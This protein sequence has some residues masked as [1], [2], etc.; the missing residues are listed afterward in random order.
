VTLLGYHRFGEHHF[1]SIFSDVPSPLGIGKLNDNY[2]THESFAALV[3]AIHENFHV[4][5]E[6]TQGFSLWNWYLDHDLAAHMAES[7]N[8]IPAGHLFKFPRMPREPSTPHSILI[9]RDDPADL[10]RQRHWERDIIRRHVASSDLAKEIIEVSTAGRG[11]QNVP[12]DALSLTTLDL[13][14]CHAAI[15][16]E[17]YIATL[18]FEQPENFSQKITDDLAGLFRVHRMAPEYNRALRIVLQL[19]QTSPGKFERGNPSPAYQHI[20]QP[21]AYEMTAFLL[22]YA[23]HTPPDPSVNVSNRPDLCAVEDMLPVVRFHKLLLAYWKQLFTVNNSGGRVALDLGRLYS[24]ES[25][26]LAQTINDANRSIRDEFG[27]VAI[28]VE[29]GTRADTFISLEGATHLWLDRLRK[30]PALRQHFPEL[31]HARMKSLELRLSDPNFW[32]SLQPVEFAVAVNVPFLFSK[33]RSGLQYFPLFVVPADVIGDEARDE[34]RQKCVQALRSASSNP[35]SAFVSKSELP[36]YVVPHRFIKSIVEHEIFCR[37]GELLL[38]GGVVMCPITGGASAA[39]SLV[40]L[41]TPAV[42]LLV[43]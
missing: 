8:D 6:L 10:A 5:Q 13:M 28:T 26:I 30:Y 22:D 7:V 39:S 38:S 20:E 27:D 12:P 17:L 21:W 36:N 19:F 29:G 37:V 33:S 15:L 9:D 18:I 16:T 24:H 42:R 40:Q 2:D 1:S 23:L 32:Y 43:N 25:P 4:M 35:E 41:E 31:F 3:T 34:Y 14:E 11:L